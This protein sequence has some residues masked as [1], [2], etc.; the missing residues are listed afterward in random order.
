MSKRSKGLQY[1]KKNQEYSVDTKI[2]GKRFRQ[3]LRARTLK[4]A[5]IEF[6][7]IISAFYIQQNNKQDLMTFPQAAAKYINEAKKKTI[8]RDVASLKAAHP[9]LKNLT[10]KQIHND[11]LQP[12][13]NA[14]KKDGIKSYTVNRDLA[15]FHRILRL[16]SDQWRT[17]NGDA[18]LASI[19]VFDKINWNDKAKPFP[20]N[21]KQQLKLFRLL[22]KHQRKMAFFA[23][24]TGLR[25]Q[26]VC[27]LRW[28][29]E[30]KIPELDTSVFIVPAKSH[31]YPDGKWKG[32]KTKEDELVVLNLVA[33]SVIEVQ[34][35]NRKGDC[36][37]V[38]P[39]QDKRISSM[40]NTSWQNAWINAG[41][42]NCKQISKGPHNLKHTYARRLRAANVPLETRKTLLH[43]KI[44]DITTH[45]SPNK[46]AELLAASE[47]VT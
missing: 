26:R 17:K 32:T 45:Y 30:V 2:N 15:V 33:K 41:F 43:Y 37:Y 9:F 11:S 31:E 35:R 23:V 25:M 29:W 28:D 8:G 44:G 46:V 3:H 20:L 7:H 42:P 16:A 22:P 27:W 38:F 24:N 1:N 36:P 40:N 39:F 18:Y 6:N 34:R 10:L 5:E 47:K 14:R 19:P 4:E 21:K 13:I 12:Y